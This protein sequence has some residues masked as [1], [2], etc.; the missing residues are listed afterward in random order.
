MLSTCRPPPQLYPLVT[1]EEEPM[2]K[3]FSPPPVPNVLADRVRA[4]RKALGINQPALAELADIKQP[5]L[6]DIESGK[7][8]ADNIKAGTCVNLARALKTSPEYLLG[9]SRSPVRPEVLEIEEAEV[10]TLYRDLKSRPKVQES[11]L[12][13]LRIL[14]DTLGPG[15]PRKANPFPKAKP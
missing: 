2:V 6:S 10:L 15:A 1:F 5:S 14:A 12:S 13:H 9:I 4:L 8:G 11:V 7:T 3:G